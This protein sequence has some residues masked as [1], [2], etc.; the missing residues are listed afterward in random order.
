M[1]PNEEQCLQM[2]EVRAYGGIEIEQDDSVLVPHWP[3]QSSQIS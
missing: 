1:D 3:T 2:A